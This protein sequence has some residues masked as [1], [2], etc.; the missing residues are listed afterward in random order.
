MTSRRRE[1]E[2][3]REI[4]QFIAMMSGKVSMEN[5]AKMSGGGGGGSKWTNSHQNSQVSSFPQPKQADTRK[6]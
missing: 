3:E 2:R 5:Q 1:R 4:G 6:S